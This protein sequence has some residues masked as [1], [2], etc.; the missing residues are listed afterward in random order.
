MRLVV[1]T[2]P[3]VLELNYTWL[4]TWIGINGRLKRDM[5]A[6]LRDAVVGLT[7]DERGLEKAHRLVID[8]LC[9]MNPGVKGLYDYLDALKYVSLE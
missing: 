4:P 7:L 8:Y 6:K 5:E 9:E 1:Q 3:G 2:E